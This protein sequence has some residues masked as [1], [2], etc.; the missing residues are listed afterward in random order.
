MRKVKQLK[1]WG[2]YENSPKEYIEYGFK[3][4]VIHPDLMGCGL[5]SPSDTDMEIDALQD[6]IDWVTNY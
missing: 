5:L 6:A 3:Y 4:T 2:I 1:K